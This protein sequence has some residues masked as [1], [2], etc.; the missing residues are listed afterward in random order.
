MGPMV[1]GLAPPVIGVGLLRTLAV[2]L[3]ASSGTEYLA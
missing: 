2:I 3:L 1:V